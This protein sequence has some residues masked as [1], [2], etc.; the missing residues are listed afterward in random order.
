M[1]FQDVSTPQ[2]STLTAVDSLITTSLNQASEATESWLDAVTINIAAYLPRLL[3]AIA[4]LIAFGLIYRYGSIFLGR[5]LRRSQR[6]SPHIREITLRIFRMT[7]WILVTL[8]ILN[9][10]GINVM[11]LLAGLGIAGLA[12]GFAAK[13]TLENLIAGVTILLDVPFEIGDNIIVDGTFGTVETLTLRSTRIRT[14]N[15]EIVIIP[16]NQMINQKVINHTKLPVLRLEI[17][18][19]IA[20]KESPQHARDVVLALTKDDPHLSPTL[21]SEVV[22]I[23]MNDS[24]VDLLLRIWIHKPHEEI[25]IRARYVEQIFNALREADIKIP[26]PHLQLFIDDAKGLA[27]LPLLN[28]GKG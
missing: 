19:S 24:S 20:Y 2:D 4:I 23:A 7:A 9:Y 6:V 10:L 22:V 3:G 27:N 13:D 17:P 26:F 11:A 16:N 1:P 25:P 21:P 15:Q 28:P 14:P 5:V 8:V 12:L 18:F